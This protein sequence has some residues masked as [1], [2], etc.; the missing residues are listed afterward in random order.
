MPQPKVSIYYYDSHVA[1]LDY[2][3]MYVERV[4]GK[5]IDDTQRP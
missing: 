1:L 3:R 2:E 4:R 5:I